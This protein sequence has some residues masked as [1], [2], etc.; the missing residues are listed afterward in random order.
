MDIVIAEAVRSAVGRG[1]KG[2]LSTKRP[3]ELAPDVIR[4]LLG[5]VPAVRGKI[6]D[7]VLGCAMPE[8]E[9][10]LNVAR[11]IALLADLG[12][13]VPAQTI[14]RFCASGLQAIAIAA[15]SIA[16]GTNEVVIAGGVESMS[17]VPMMGFNP[18]PSP[19][20]MAKLPGAHMAMGIT[21]ENVA[22]RFGITR[23]M[24]DDCAYASQV[25][26]K[27]AVERGRFRDEIV[28]VCA[29]GERFER[30]ELPRPDTT[31]D[32]L[33]K[34]KPA[35][36]EGGSVTAGNSSPISDGAAAC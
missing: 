32:G 6:D 11:L 19:V 13:E 10:G 7:V 17:S 22:N 36:A 16:I 25:K 30:D 31:L 5:R 4:G 2:S 23:G 9:Q 3:D 15:G 14:N 34:L 1:H 26:A 20:L 8:G 33:A 28:P 21:A 18:S 24:Q 12:V 29:A 27:A 35:F